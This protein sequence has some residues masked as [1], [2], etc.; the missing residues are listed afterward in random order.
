M[1]ICKNTA[2]TLVYPKCEF[3]IVCMSQFKRKNEESVFL[4]VVRAFHFLPI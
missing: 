4:P 2:N 3:R 1:K